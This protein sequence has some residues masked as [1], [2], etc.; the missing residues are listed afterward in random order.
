MHEKGPETWDSEYHIGKT[1]NHPLNLRVFTE[2]K[3]HDPASKV[4]HVRVVLLTSSHIDC[5]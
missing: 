1:Q 4:R 2:E 3:R 5:S